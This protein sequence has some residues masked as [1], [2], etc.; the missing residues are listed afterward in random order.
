MKVA[1]VTLF[2]EVFSSFLET[3]LV[4]RAIDKQLLSVELVNPRD[5]AEPP[6]FHVDDTPYGGGAGMVLRPEPLS[7]A[8]D[9]AKLLLPEAIIIFLT[10][11]GEQ[12]CQQQSEQFS[13]HDQFIFLCG[14]YE[15]VDQ[16][17]VDLYVDRELSIGDYVL[18]GGELPA[19]VVIE[20]VL[21]LRQEVL[22]NIE[23]T[24]HESF[25]DTDDGRVL[26][27]PQYTRPQK[28]RDVEVPEVLLSGD[29]AR[30]HAWRREQSR[31]KTA[32]RRPELLQ[33]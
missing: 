31:K 4:A 10:P 6:H 13:Q 5:F 17:V 22:G 2:P 15:G 8:L 27:G 11:S 12:F 30:I 18:M 24:Q 33:S 16:R 14:R 25:S 28:F 26:E 1:I 3:S 7:R 20:S 23:S 32:A 9:H 29:H 19:M 21:R